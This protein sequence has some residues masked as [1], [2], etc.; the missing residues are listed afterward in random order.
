VLD[1]VQIIIC[2]GRE[3]LGSIKRR[4]FTEKMN[5]YKHLKQQ[6]GLPSPTDQIVAK[7]FLPSRMGLV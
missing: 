6:Q 3:H 7:N 5:D 1:G 2:Y 4:E